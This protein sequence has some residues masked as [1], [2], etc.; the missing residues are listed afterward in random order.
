MDWAFGVICKE[1]LSNPSYKFFFS[2]GV[3]YFCSLYLFLHFELFCIHCKLRFIFYF[4]NGYLI[5]PESFVEET[6][7]SIELPSDFCHL[8]HWM[9][10]VWMHNLFF[11]SSLLVFKTLKPMISF[12]THFFLVPI[13]CKK[14]STNVGKGRIQL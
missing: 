11:V 1:S 9:T 8:K 2:L 4:A 13:I 14:Y 3:L 12:H 7:F 10:C 6:T 5:L